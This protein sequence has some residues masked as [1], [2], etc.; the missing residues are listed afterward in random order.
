LALFF[1]G[2]VFPPL[3][4]CGFPPLFGGFFFKSATD[5]FKLFEQLGFFDEG[6]HFFWRGPIKEVWGFY[7]KAVCNSSFSVLKGEGRVFIIRAHVSW[8]H[9]FRRGPFRKN[10]RSE[11]C[12]GG[13][14]IVVSRAFKRG[15][16]YQT[17]CVCEAT[18]GR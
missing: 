1:L 9:S 17:R 6:N 7:T 12:P 5:F 10:L 18:R 3:K 8:R 2:R 4:I 15:S 13:T 16:L 11:D 14:K